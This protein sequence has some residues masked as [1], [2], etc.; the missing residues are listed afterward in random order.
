M[1]S[2]PFLSHSTYFSSFPVSD[3]L[4]TFVAKPIIKVLIANACAWD[5]ISIPVNRHNSL[6]HAKIYCCE[7]LNGGWIM[8]SHWFINSSAPPCLVQINLRCT[9]LF[10]FST[11]GCCDSN[12]PSPILKRFVGLFL[13]L[14]SLSWQLTLVTDCHTFAYFHSLKLMCEAQENCLQLHFERASRSRKH[15]RK[16]IVDLVSE[17]RETRFTLKNIHNFMFQLLTSSRSGNNSNRKL[18]VWSRDPK[19]H[20][21]NYLE[22]RFVSLA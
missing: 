14:Y 4:S 5:D 15:E 16:T 1:K 21:R 17:W 18:C 19:F 12:R 20:P 13:L 2:F 6:I 7:L 11:T 10:S 8:R 3:D 9:F 22:R